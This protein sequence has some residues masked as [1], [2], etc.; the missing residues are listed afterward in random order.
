[1]PAF[2]IVP[3][4]RSEIYILGVLM[5]LTA[6]ACRFKQDKANNTDLYKCGPCLPDNIIALIIIIAHL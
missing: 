5:V 2:S 3:H 6:G 4:Q 1:M